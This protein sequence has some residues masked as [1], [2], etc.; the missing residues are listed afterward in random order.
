MFSIVRNTV[1]VSRRGVTSGDE[2]SHAMFRVSLNLNLLQSSRKNS[3]ARVEKAA[4]GKSQKTPAEVDR[5]GDWAQE[6][7]RV[8]D[9]LTRRDLCE[10]FG[11]KLGGCSMKCDKGKRRVDRTA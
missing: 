10:T 6:Q 4:E 7:E 5:R 1:P 8:V 3:E 2:E 11:D 9:R